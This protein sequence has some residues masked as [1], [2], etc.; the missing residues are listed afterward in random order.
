MN[1]QNR[2][3]TEEEWIEIEKKNQEDPDPRKPYH[4]QVQDSL[5]ETLSGVAEIAK[6]ITCNIKKEKYEGK[7]LDLGLRKW[8][9]ASFLVSYKNINVKVETIDKNTTRWYFDFPEHPYDL[10]IETL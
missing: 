3:P 10:T 4:E 5:M 1:K 8:Y 9:V 7:D 6:S 2:M